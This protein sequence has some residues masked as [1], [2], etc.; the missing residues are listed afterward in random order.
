MPELRAFVVA[1]AQ[2]SDHLRLVID[3]HVFR[4]GALL[5][6]KPGKTIEIEQRTAGRRFWSP[7]DLPTD[8]TWPGLVFR[9]LGGIRRRYRC[10]HRA[11]ARHWRGRS[12]NVKGIP[13]IGRLVRVRLGSEC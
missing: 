5:D 7:Y 13:G 11:H 6:V 3:A 9:I 4:V 1:A 8:P 12:P 2:A 10:R